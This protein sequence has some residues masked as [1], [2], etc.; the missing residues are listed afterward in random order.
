MS[1]NKFSQQILNVAEEIREKYKE[2][3]PA[4]REGFLLGVEYRQNEID[5][6]KEKYRVCKEFVKSKKGN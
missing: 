5:M 6:I 2:I 1:S 3:G 4:V